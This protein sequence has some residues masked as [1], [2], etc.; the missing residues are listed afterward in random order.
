MRNIFFIFSTYLLSKS[1]LFQMQRY[2]GLFMLLFKININLG[3]QA[4]FLH[5]VLSKEF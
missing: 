4:M 5:M 2:V 1:S 3:I